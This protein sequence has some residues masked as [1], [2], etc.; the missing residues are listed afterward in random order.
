MGYNSNCFYDYCLWGCCNY[1][2]T[3]PENYSTGNSDFDSCYYYYT[4]P[5]GTIAGAVV[6]SVIGLI[7]IF[8]IIKRY[9]N[10]QNEEAM[11]IA[12]MNANSNHNQSDTIIITPSQPT[13]GQPGYGQPG[14]GQPIYGQPGYGQPGYGQPG[15]GQ[16]GYG[17]QPAQPII[18]VN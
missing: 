8:F 17:Q 9:R 2:G 11:R 18:I 6:G 3:C 16:P 14:Y 15:Y 7:I 1:Y 10:H 12:A 13:Y 5:P 4:T